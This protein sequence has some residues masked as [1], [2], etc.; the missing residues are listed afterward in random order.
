[1]RE[2][3]IQ[4]VTITLTLKQLMQVSRALGLAIGITKVFASTNP[5]LELDS[6]IKELQAANKTWESIVDSATVEQISNNEG[7]NKK[8]LTRF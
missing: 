4:E 2:L 6:A 7:D 1:M 3:T 8:C 5:K